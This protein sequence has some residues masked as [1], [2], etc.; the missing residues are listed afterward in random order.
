MAASSRWFAVVLVCLFAVASSVWATATRGDDPSNINR[1]RLYAERR[2]EAAAAA[3]NWTYIPSLGDKARAGSAEAQYELAIAYA[4]GILVTQNRKLALAW[5]RKAAER[6][7]LEAQNTVADM[8]GSDR[9]SPEKK[10][11]SL[12]WRRKAAERGHASAQSSL[13]TAYRYGDGVPKDSQAA[14]KW[15]EKAAQQGNA[16]GQFGLAMSYALGDGAPRDDRLALEWAQKAAN[17]GNQVAQF[18]MGL[19]YA[20]GLLGVTKNMEAAMTWWQKSADQGWTDAMLKL[21][22]YY[23][24]GEEVPKDNVQGLMWMTVAKRRGVTGTEAALRIFKNEMP[25]EEVAEA[26]RRADAWTPNLVE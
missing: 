17:T 3:K 10:A 20:D 8:L 9:A 18:Y 1:D 5:M 2:L 22:R 15:H 25:P 14:T 11:E 16:G 13:G 6:G 21:S 24:L 7:A 4:S 26:L 12:V 19:V 23:A